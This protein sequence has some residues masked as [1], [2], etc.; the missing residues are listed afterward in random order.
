MQRKTKTYSCNLSFRFSSCC[1]SSDWPP[2]S[3]PPAITCAAW[4]RF[5]TGSP[6]GC[7]PAPGGDSAR[8]SEAPDELEEADERVALR[9]GPD[10]ALPLGHKAGVLDRLD[11]AAPARAACSDRPLPAAL[12]CAQLAGRPPI[13]R[14]PDCM[15]LAL[16]ISPPLSLSGARYLSLAR[17]LA[18]CC[19]YL[20]HLRLLKLASRPRSRSSPQTDWQ[21]E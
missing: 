11:L 20:A 5:A 15:S 2:A 19:S 4:P 13:G 1:C 9:A 8:P 6:P 18:L 14:W 12:I 10:P 17:P 7:G 3:S 16:S 21:A